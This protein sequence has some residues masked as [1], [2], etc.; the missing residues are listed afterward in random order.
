MD[1]SQENNSKKA[2][3][4]RGAGVSK[5]TQ[6]ELAHGWARRDEP[7]RHGTEEPGEMFRGHKAE[8]LGCRELG[9]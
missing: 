2:V 4:G 6:A 7:G 9:L 1:V 8:G 3:P 5:G